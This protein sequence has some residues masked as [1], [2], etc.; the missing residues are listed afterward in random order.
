MRRKPFVMQSIC[1]AMILFGMH[2]CFFHA[3]LPAGSLYKFGICLTAASFWFVLLAAAPLRRL[4]ARVKRRLRVPLVR[5]PVADILLL[6]TLL[7]GIVLTVIYFDHLQKDLRVLYEAVGHRHDVYYSHV[8]E[9]FDPYADKYQGATGTWLLLGLELLVGFVMVEAFSHRH[10]MFLGT[11]PPALLIAGGLLLGQAP[12]IVSMILVIC[13]VLGMQLVSDEL[14]LGGAKHFRQLTSGGA[15][16]RL[17]YP[18]L[19]LVLLLVFGA[20]A[21]LSTAT[22]DSYFRGEESLLQFQHSFEKKAVDLG[23]RLVQRIQMLLGIEQP[24]VLTNVAPAYSGETVLTLTADKKPK[25]DIYLRGFIGT[26]YEDGNWSSKSDY[27]IADLFSQDICY[28]LLTQDYTVYQANEA[29]ESFGEDASEL[30]EKKKDLTGQ[31]DMT[32]TI[33]YAKDNLSTFAFFPYYAKLNEDSMGILMLDYD[34]GFRRGSGVDEYKVTMQRTDKAARNK[35]LQYTDILR[36]G[37]VPYYIDQSGTATIYTLGTAAPFAS[38]VLDLGESRI[39]PSLSEGSKYVAV[40]DEKLGKYFQYIM[41]EDLWLPEQGL[42]QTRELAAALVEEGTV[43]LTLKGD[44]D[45]PATVQGVIREMQRYFAVNTQYSKSLKSVGFREDYVENFLFKQRKGFC[46]HYATAGAVLFRA[47]G[48]PARYVSGYKVPASDF[49][50]DSEG[51]YTAKVI[52]SEAHAW[53]EIYTVNEGWTVADMTP[54]EADVQGESTASNE[55]LSSTANPEDGDD[56]FL[57][58]DPESEDKASGDE[59]EEATKEPEET[60]EPTEEAAGTQE[61]ENNNTTKD[62]SSAEGSSEASDT[63]EDSRSGISEEQKKGLLYGAAALLVLIA[64]WLVWYSQKWRRRRRLKRCR[65]Q[66]EYL[67]E[68][69][70]QLEQYLRCCGYRKV[71]DLSDREYIALLEQLFPRGRENGQLQQY[72]R[73]LEQARFDRE[74]GN[75]E[76]IRRCTRLLRSVQGAALAS[77]SILRRLYVCGLRGWSL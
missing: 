24:G 21:R 3:F 67:L 59:K 50:K 73:L 4:E 36:T 16:H 18:V 20:A 23:V 37:I 66:R 63:G 61:K 43:N 2:L 49:E 29:A 72:Y 45:T 30:L 69:N 44:S 13:G 6:V 52:D 22:Q 54:G 15:Q 68:L 28:Q 12:G 65:T 64:V 11:L 41:S 70:R 17:F 27:D 8:Q 38:R 7:L 76:E 74:D 60:P 25:E 75:R 55:S 40:S 14:Y 9:A 35:L 77:K 46:E 19:L 58:N 42:E 71:S 31:N 47:M 62:N 10:G 48:V 57:E 33:S 53:T 26:K 51:T 34:R 56:A 32:L 39:L 1:L 5:Y